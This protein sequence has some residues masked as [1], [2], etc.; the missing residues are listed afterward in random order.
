MKTLKEDH[1]ASVMNATCRSREVLD[2]IADKWTALIIK[3]LSDGTLRHGELRRRVTGISQKMLTQT[4]RRL[5]YDGLVNRKVFPV[6]PP[7]VEYSLTALGRSL[8]GPLEAICQWAEKHA[9]EMA[10]ARAKARTKKGG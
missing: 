10:L 5:E 3:V 2:R 7:M 6:V 8:I 1:P 9:P 4:L